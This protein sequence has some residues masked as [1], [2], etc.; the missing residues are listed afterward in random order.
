[1]STNIRFETPENI[2]VAYHPAGLG[3]RFI[4]WFV[5]NII[6]TIA[7]FALFIILIVSGVITDSV[8]RDIVDPA[9]DPG[10]RTVGRTPGDASDVPLYFIGVFLLV[11]GLGS[12]AYYGLSEL[13]LRGQTLG[14][15]VSAIRVV[16]LDG[17]ALDPAGVFVRNIFRIIDQLPPLWVVPLLSKQSQRLGDMV[18]GTV[19]VVDKPESISNLR[20]ALA[21]RPAVEAQFVFDASMLKRVR[22]GDFVAVEKILER[23]GQLNEFQQDTFLG[24]LVTPLAARLKIDPPPQ[25]QRLQFLQDLLAAEYRRQHRS[26]G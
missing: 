18:A 15:R 25:D 22:S 4:A 2:Q 23:W 6:L 24:Q 13:F 21:Q 5:D 20:V 12:F 16:R 8:V 1:M 10:R 7:G 26:L 11:W 17:F 3:T 9:A 14:K 19:V